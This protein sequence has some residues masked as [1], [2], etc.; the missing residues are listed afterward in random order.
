MISELICFGVGFM[1]GL[2]TALLIIWWACG[3]DYDKFYG[4]YR[5]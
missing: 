5:G 2:A 1:V 3:D 4:E